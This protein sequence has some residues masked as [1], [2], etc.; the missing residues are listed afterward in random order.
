MAQEQIQ[1]KLQIAKILSSQKGANLIYDELNHIFRTDGHNKDNS[2]KY[3]RCMS[4]NCPARI[5]TPGDP[6]TREMNG[7]D[8]EFFTILKTVKSHTEACDRISTSSKIHLKKMAKEIKDTA[9]ST[10]HAPSQILASTQSNLDDQTLDQ[11][12]KDIH[13]SRNIRRYRHIAEAAPHNP[14]EKT[15]FGIP[16]EYKTITI[17]KNEVIFLLHDTGEDDEDRILIFGTHKGLDDISNSKNIGLDGTFD[18]APKCYEKGQM[19][20]IH[21]IVQHVAI[22]RLYTLLPNKKT[23]TYKRLYQLLKEMRPDMKPESAL[24]DFELANIKALKE[25]FNGITLWGCLFHLSQNSYRKIV[26]IGYKV[27][28]ARH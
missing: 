11:A 3:W 12:Q 25:E 5:H 26:E 17:D 2:K 18:I 19:V 21:K 24:L 13:L 8:E 27:T 15:G 14:T 6:E 7:N 9:L 1:E 23:E 22:P 16:H 20:S 4:A 28:Y 10:Q